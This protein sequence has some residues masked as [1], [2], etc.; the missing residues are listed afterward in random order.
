MGLTDADRDLFTAVLGEHYAAGRL[1]DAGLAR[2]V[3]LVLTASDLDQAGAALEGL[4][5][6]AA[7]QV[8]RRRWGKRHGEAP[9]PRP[10][11]VPTS[12]RFRDPSSGAVMR[13]WVDA[14]DGSRHYLADGSVP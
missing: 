13:V 6:M 8:R 11:W 7:P 4:P 1:D 9:G 14:G 2:R 3:H 12:E 10:G 5:A